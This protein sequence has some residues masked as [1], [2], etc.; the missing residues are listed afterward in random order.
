MKNNILM[1]YAPDE[2]A[3]KKSACCCD[4]TGWLKRD[5]GCCPENR[6]D[7]LDGCGIEN[8]DP[9]PGF[10]SSGSSFFGCG[11]NKWPD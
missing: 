9:G 1:R 10:R 8:S 4:V 5:A 3:V 6:L 7:R 2:I 11:I